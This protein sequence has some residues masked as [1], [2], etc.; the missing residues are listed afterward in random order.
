MR[1]KFFAAGMPATKGSMR[2]FVRGGR[3]VVT[4]DNA[5]TKPWQAVIGYAATQAGVR[6]AS[7]PVLV[8]ARFYFPRPSGHLGKRGLKPSAPAHPLTRSS[9]DVDKLARALLDAL[10]G[11]A[12]ADDSQVVELRASKGWSD[13]MR[14]AG[15]AVLIETQEA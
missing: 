11:V 7:G 15:V 2:A 8:E 4:H 10:T 1:F 3:P 14:G 9:G 6:L 5:R 13:E 12:Y